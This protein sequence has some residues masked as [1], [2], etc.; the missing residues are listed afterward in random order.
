MKIQNMPNFGPAGMPSSQSMVNEIMEAQKA[1]IKQAENIKERLVEEKNEYSNLTGLVDGLKEA[2]GGLATPSLFT[3]LKAESS[4]PEILEAAISGVALPGN[5]EFEVKGLAQAAKYLEAG[6]PDKESTPVG[7]GY[8]GIETSDGN[9]LDIT[10][11]PGSTL[12]D[13]ASKINEAT[14]DYKA[15]IINTG[16]AEDPFKLLVS[17]VKT[18]IET[19]IHIDEDTTFLNFK[20]LKAGQDL[21]LNFEDVQVTGKE[22]KL[23]DLLDGLSID[24]KKAAPGTKVN[25]N[26]TADVDTSVETIKGFTDKYNKI[27]DFANNQR[28]PN[29]EGKLGNLSSDSGLRTVVRRLQSSVTSPVSKEGTKFQSLAEVGITTNAKTGELQ[30]DETKLSNALKTDHKDV[31]ELFAYSEKGSGLANKISDATKAL[32]DSTSG[33]LKSR[34]NSLQHQIQNQDKEIERQ[35]KRFDDTKVRLEKQFAALDS[36][37]GAMQNQSNFLNARLNAPAPAK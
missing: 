4:H 37:L 33:V 35:T 14:S 34:N 20:N 10:I 9:M 17:S 19:K 22:N 32:T 36:N 1:P 30:V 2:V 11:D 28:V 5:Y 8:M 31:M 6:F 23:N 29:A 12:N 24:L 18:G 27:L 15:Q 26:I 16:Q 7:F 3:K 13:V 21:D 25:L